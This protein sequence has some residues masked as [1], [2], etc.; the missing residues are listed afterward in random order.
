MVVNQLTP[1]Q[2]RILVKIFC[3]T[4]RGAKTRLTDLIDNLALSAVMVEK[5]CGEMEAQEMV[6]STGGDYALTVKGRDNIKVVM[7]G[8]VFDIIHPGHVFTLS[9]SKKLGDVLV[10]SVARDK[11]VRSSKG[12]EPLNGEAARLE[13]VNSLKSVDL[14]VLGSERNIFDTVEKVRPNV[15]ALGYDQKHN[16][17]EVEKEARKR[18]ILLEVVRLESPVP[19]IKSSV[20][21]KDAS[22]VKEF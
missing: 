19:N 18:G 14:A 20:I 2:K 1:L 12:H 4:L 15:I 7:A 21:L 10:V 5:I 6:R 22:R 3:D 11:N 16:E 8:G 17:E 13:L 9:S